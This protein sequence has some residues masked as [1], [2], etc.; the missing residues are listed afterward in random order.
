MILPGWTCSCGMFSGEDKECIAKCRV[1]GAERP[2]I[3]NWEQARESA[4]A[5]LKGQ[6]YRSYVETAKE[7]A[8]FIENGTRTHKTFDAD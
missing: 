5:A 6:P 4:V 2:T 7:L 3:L 1:C 8:A